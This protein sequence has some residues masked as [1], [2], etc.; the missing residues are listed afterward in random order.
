L[1]IHRNALIRKDKIEA[2]Q[3]QEDGRV[4]LKLKGISDG[5]EVSRRHLSSVRK[6]MKS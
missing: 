1:R 4:L 2:L 3:K 5:L 6:I